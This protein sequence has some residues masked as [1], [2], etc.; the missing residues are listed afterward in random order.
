MERTSV[1]ELS[2]NVQS[3]GLGRKAKFLAVAVVA[4]SSNLRCTKSEDGKECILEDENKYIALIP[5]SGV[6]PV[7]TYALVDIGNA[8]EASPGIR[9]T[10]SEAVFYRHQYSEG[11]AEITTTR[12]NRK[13]AWK[14][15]LSTGCYK[16]C[17][18]DG[19]QE[20]CSDND[21]LA[22]ITTVLQ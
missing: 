22:V 20:S 11:C 6:S 13:R 3:E 2:N 19:H 14:H 12:E 21:N 8:A 15:T 10:N 4:E 9:V 7:K 16:W 1:L 18:S 17:C 5:T